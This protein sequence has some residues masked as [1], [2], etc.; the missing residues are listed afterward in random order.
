MPKRKKIWILVLVKR[1]FIQEPEV[2]YD[3]NKAQIRKRVL[4]SD[5]NPDYD[6]IDIFE[7]RLAIDKVLV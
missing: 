4:M 7:K 6:E 3:Q 1:G 2:F 5:F